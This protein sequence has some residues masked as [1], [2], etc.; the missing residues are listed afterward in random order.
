M[1]ISGIGATGTNDSSLFSSFVDNPDSA[2]GKTDFLE[3]L[4][5]KLQHQDPMKP[6]TDESF[7]AD[8]AQFSSLEQM[9]NMNSGFSDQVDMIASLN[10]NLVGL[11]MMQNTTQ[12]AA[13]IGKNVVAQYETTDPVTQEPTQV[14]V[15]GSVDVVRF[16]D[17]TPKIVVDGNEYDLSSVKEIKA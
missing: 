13:L 4:V 9:Q 17:G 2:L 5:T 12:A 1:S 7:I 10:E 14:T 15:E 8:M 16:V 6:M 11:M 3:L